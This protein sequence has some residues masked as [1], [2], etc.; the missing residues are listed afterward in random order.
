MSG[1]EAAPPV[2]PGPAAPAAAGTAHAGGNAAR[3]KVAARD[4]AGRNGAGRP[5]L[6]FAPVSRAMLDRPSVQR[7]LQSIVELAAGTVAGVSAAGV[8]VPGR[9]GEIETPA[10]TDERVPRADRAQSRY[11][12]GP[13]IAAAGRNRPALITIDDMAGEHRWPRFTA[14][15]SRIGVG[16]LV[17]CSLPLEHGGTAALSLHAGTAHAFDDSAARAAAVYAAHCFAA[18]GQA[19]LVESLRAAMQSRQVIG[20][21]TGVLMERHRVDP[22]TAF[23]MLIRASQRLNIK[24]RLVAEHVVRTGLDPQAIRTGDG[25]PVR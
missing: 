22:R 8:S 6:P 12:E 16:S 1:I 3:M 19:F 24:L 11:R 21:A 15:A 4:R 20:E 10:Y 13:C 14:A 23:G 25:Q 18:V 2:A 7:T 17:A 5:G 9:G